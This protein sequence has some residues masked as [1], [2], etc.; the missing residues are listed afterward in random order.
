MTLP[1]TDERGETARA[2]GSG[3]SPPTFRGDRVA[4]TIDWEAVHHDFLHSGMALRRIADKH[5]T[6]PA[7]IA[8]RRDDRGWERVA[9]LVRLP[10][11]RRPLGN[12][13]PPTPTEKRRGRIVKR[14]YNLLDAKM[15]E[16]ETRMAENDGRPQSAAEAEREAR[17]L[18]SLA[19]LYAKLVEMDEA[20]AA[21]DKGARGGKDRKKT[22]DGADAD[23]LRRDL[24]GR[25][26][27]IQPGDD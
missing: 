4:S 27:R 15:S 12:G 9:P 5:G 11:R 22:Q 14:L 10:T 26:A 2:D 6:T 19:R 24:A 21:Q 3:V 13:L 1:D 17:N 8:K 25:L 7:N 18:N 16:I 23:R 20:K